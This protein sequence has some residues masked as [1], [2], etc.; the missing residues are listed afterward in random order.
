MKTHICKSLLAS[1]AVL[2]LAGISHAQTISVTPSAVTM[3]PNSTTNINITFS[4]WSG[5]NVRVSVLDFPSYLGNP[6]L[7]NDVGPD[8]MPRNMTLTAGATPGTGAH[9]SLRAEDFPVF[10]NSIATDIPVIVREFPDAPLSLTTSHAGHVDAGTSTARVTASPN[11]SAT[12][13]SHWVDDTSRISSV[14][15]SSNIFTLTSPQTAS[16]GVVTLYTVWRDTLLGGV[17]TNSIALNVKAVPRIDS[18][19]NFNFD[20]DTIHTESFTLTYGDAE[21]RLTYGAT[22]S[23]ANIIESYQF[24]GAK[25]AKSLVLTPYANAYGT[26]MAT[27]VVGDGEHSATQTITVVVNPIPDPPQISG[28]P[29]DVII[30]NKDSWTNV[31]ASVTITDP[32]D[33]PPPSTQKELLNVF[34]SNTVGSAAFW[35]GRSYDLSA[36]S[37]N[38]YTDVQT[39]WFS[40]LALVVRNDSYLYEPIGTTNTYTV[41]ISAISTNDGLSCVTSLPIRVWFQNSLP[42]FEVGLSSVSAVES[43]M[44]LRPFILEEFDDV[45]KDQQQYT[46]SVRL[47]PDSEKFA[48]FDPMTNFVVVGTE[49]DFRDLDALLKSVQFTAKPG[50]MTNEEEILTFIFELDDGYDTVTVTNSQFILYQ[51]RNAPIVTSGLVTVPKPLYT[52]SSTSAAAPLLPKITVTDADEGGNQPVSVAVGIVP[53]YVKLN[54]L[55][56]IGIERT[57]A[58][59]TTALRGVTFEPDPAALGAVP[60]GAEVTATITFT[61]TDKRG[62]TSVPLSV[63]INVRKENAA[64]VLTVPKD[65]PLVLSP[66]NPI[67]PFEHIGLSNDD[68]NRVTFTFT[69]DD[70]GKGGF[71]NVTNAG[72]TQYGNGYTI[73]DSISNILALVTNVT[74]TLSSSYQ[75][76]R[77]DPGGTTFSL[78]ARDS[79]WALAEKTI[80]IQVQEP[81]RNWLVTNPIDDG[82]P[83]SLSH[84]LM[85]FGNNDVITFALPEYP[86]TIRLANAGEI[87]ARTALT[88]KGPGAD[89]LTISGDCN[90]DGRPD[91]R[92]LTVDAPVTVEGLTVADCTGDLG[93]A[94][95][96][97]ENGRL[98]LRQVTVRNC[99]A[100]EWSGAVDVLMGSLIVESSMFLDNSTTENAWGGGG[101]ITLFTDKANLFI[102]TVFARNRQRNVEGKGGGA[103]YAEFPGELPG[104]L[105]TDIIHC[106]FVGNDDATEN[107]ILQATSILANGG[108]AFYIWN[109]IFADN[110]ENR[111]LNAA[112]VGEIW[113]FGGNVCDDDSTAILYQNGWVSHD[114]LDSAIDTLEFDPQLDASFVPRNLTMPYVWSEAAVDVAGRIRDTIETISG[115]IDEDAAAFP[116]I[117][118]IQFLTGMGGAPVSDRF[119]EIYAPRGQETVNLNGMTL[120]VNGIAVHTFGEGTLAFTNNAYSA[121]VPASA[122]AASYLLAPGRGVV[123]VF[124]AASSGLANFQKPLALDNITP[125]VRASVVSNATDL[126]ALLSSVG[127]GTVS[128]HNR[129]GKEIVHHTF[130]A[131]YN[132]PDSAGGTNALHIG[133]QSITTFPQGKGFAFLPHKHYQ[134]ALDESPGQTAEGTPFGGDNAPPVINDDVAVTTEDAAVN[135][136]VL[137]NDVDPDN[138]PL[139]IVSFWPTSSL[140]AAV[141]MSGIGGIL[142]DPTARVDIQMLP[143]GRQIKDSFKYTAIDGRTFSIGTNLTQ[144]SNYGTSYAITCALDVAHG[145][146]TNDVLWIENQTVSVTNVINATTFVF[147]TAHEAWWIDTTSLHNAEAW[148]RNPATAIEGTVT[149][150]LEGLNDNPVGGDDLLVTSLTERD[151]VRM[152]AHFSPIPFPDMPTNAVA[153]VGLLAND[154]DVD[155]GDTNETFR[156]TG[157]LSSADVHPV[158]DIQSSTNGTATIITSAAHGLETGMS[159]VLVGVVNPA[160]V[161]GSRVVTVIDENTF[162]I[163]IPLTVAATFSRAHWIPVPV[164]LTATT[165]LGAS[166]TLNTRANPQAN[167]IVYNAAVSTQL[168]ALA[169]GEQTEDGFW[170]VFVDAYEAPA[171]AYVSLT[172]TGVN[173]PP[174]VTDDPPLDLPD[175]FGD[176]WADILT[177]RLTVLTVLV[178]PESGVTGC[179]DLIVAEKGK[180]NLVSADLAMLTDFYSTDEDTPLPIWASDLFANDTDTDTNDLAAARHFISDVESLSLRG[181]AVSVTNGINILYNPQG[182][183]ELQALGIGETAFDIFTVYVSDG[184]HSVSSR[185]AVLVRGVNDK[186]AAYPVYVTNSPVASEVMFQ[187]NVV[188]IDAGDVFPPITVTVPDTSLAT[189]KIPYTV[190]DQSLFLALDDT[191][192]VAVNVASS[193]LDVLANDVNFHGTGIRLISVTPSLVGGVVTVD[194]AAAVLRYTPPADFR[195]TDIFTYSATNAQGLVRKANVRVRVIDH[196]YNGPLQACDDEYAVARD[197]GCY[198]P[199]TL[200]DALIP[201]SADGIIIDPTYNADW[202]SGLTLTNNLFRYESIGDS[203]KTEVVFSYR[204]TGGGGAVSSARVRVKIIDRVTTIQPDW[205]TAAPNEE[206]ALDLLANDI[207]FGDSVAGMQITAVTTNATVGKVII[208]EGRT[209]VLYTAQ[210]GF[211]GQDAFEYAVVDR[212]GGVGIAQVVVTVGLPAFHAMDSVTVATN[213]VTLLDVLANETVRPYLPPTSLT[214]TGVTLRDGEIANGIASVNNNAVRFEAG[215]VV[216]ATAVWL[217]TA[218]MPGIPSPSIITGELTV[219]TSEVGKL[220]ANRD[221]LTVRMNAVDVPVDVLA[222]DLSFNRNPSALSV[223]DFHMYSSEGGTI[224][225]N[226][227]VLYYTPR[228]GFTGLDTFAYKAYDGVS[229]AD[230]M[231]TVYVTAGDLVANDDAFTVGYEWDGDAG[232]AKA[233]RLPVLDNDGVFPGGSATL[234]VSDFGLGADVPQHGSAVELSD[235]FRFVLFRPGARPSPSAYTETFTYEVEDTQGRKKAARVQVTVELRVGEIEIETQDDV[236]VVEFNSTENVL[237]VSANDLV[238]PKTPLLPSTLH[239]T[240]TPQFGEIRGDGANLIYTPPRGFVGI[241]TAVYTLSDGLGGSGTANVRIYVGSLPTAP[242]HYSVLRGTTSLFDIVANDA[243]RPDYATPYVGA[244]DSVFGA[245]HDASLSI[246]GSLVQY[247]PDSAYSGTYPYTEWFSYTLKDDSAR[248]TTGTVSVVVY[249]MAGSLASSVVY[250]I[251][252]DGIG[253]TQ[254]S[255]REEWD[256]K[257]FTPVQFANGDVDGCADPDGDG[258]TNDAEYVFGGDPNNKDAN[259]GY[260]YINYNADGS[261]DIWYVRRADDEDLAFHL[262]GRESLSVGDWVRIDSLATIHEVAYPTSADTERETATH[263]IAVPGA[264]RFFKIVVDL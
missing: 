169:E 30:S 172:V 235:D 260:I 77:D 62:L 90:G 65:Q 217:Y 36:V 146:V 16:S 1:I 53:P 263:H 22:F 88:I 52:I 143:A 26:V 244:V 190:T 47:T 108:C 252:P 170:Y 138:D 9:V 44:P 56:D 125:I 194:A 140:G 258:L 188:D 131:V 264:Y 86:A 41:L 223:W 81:P 213:T 256:A 156:I 3:Y 136:D 259:V 208:G 240:A 97:K 206:I 132:D 79:F 221:N 150:T 257:N 145:L 225:Q 164:R 48:Y 130:L 229:L 114:L 232:K 60:I 76:P 231:V 103:I 123:I 67:R 242:D 118:E 135:I 38:K 126:A 128:I 115:A 196:D 157:V 193:P 187:P 195:G 158:T 8:L 137:A 161:N 46:L 219:V 45:D 98:T 111:S 96:V 234:T 14:L 250:V 75:F 251:N 153:G 93:G 129:A 175:D 142:Y 18:F 200:N 72:F 215:A 87:T 149:V 216:N 247:T 239:V 227:N 237:P 189:N 71:G 162:S 37:S 226:G 25:P 120:L 91:R 178:P 249:D 163:P 24:T 205:F 198:L 61:A 151:A 2:F 134:S 165:P 35:L 121:G 211:L 167:N 34:V 99:E 84:A 214:L 184:Y 29:S 166:V 89:M 85:R 238:E 253:S 186:P 66:S 220:Y 241:D 68:T 230:G 209:N 154:W 224:R 63:E 173:N 119:I 59:L 127:R 144:G 105:D 116:V 109:T 245:S 171:V 124:P 20:E 13:V 80:T 7:D 12:Y 197:M 82:A 147:V 254:S 179:A 107:P 27:V 177:N 54:G 133:T 183:A 74:F 31:F 210:A 112:S 58:G 185:V 222:N 139:T 39:A 174:E 40:N 261:V 5:A 141:T 246:V 199:V 248:V 101:A 50:V 95:A 218:E 32:D 159:V 243:V 201:L 192:R 10:A 155:E 117:T 19:S 104:F 160:V 23:P 102:N 11:S 203:G 236:F 94:F 204:V 122:N 180:G 43:D 17:C 92:F 168:Q 49:F 78:T 33:F 207:L 83:G 191:F 70:P 233:Y 148:T 181:A 42:E 15:P 28:L 113:S 100:T 106:T 228:L 57:P 21:S 51:A 255:V 73:T 212:Y 4:G 6:V 202:P 55:A 69:M 176:D 64:P 152:L 182:S 110:P 262:E